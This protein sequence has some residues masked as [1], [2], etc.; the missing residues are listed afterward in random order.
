MKI[1]EKFAT[2]RKNEE[3]AF[4]TYLTAGFPSL[5]ESIENIYLLSECG[6]DIIELGVPFSDPIA[7]G[8]SIQYA[9][10]IALK[11]GITLKELLM[12]LRQVKID[13]P[14]VLM[15][16]LNP[17][18]S[19]KKEELF[20]DLKGTG[21]SGLIIPD[22]PVEES[23]AWV[24]LSNGYGINIIFLVAPTSPTERIRLIATK[25]QGFIYCV[26]VTG[27]TGMRSSLPPNIFQFVERVKSVT[28]KP[29]AVGF[30]I[31]SPEQIKLLKGKADGVI[32][33]SRIVEAIRQ[34][35]NLKDILKKL[36]EST[37]R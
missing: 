4:I 7:D 1:D 28:D 30:G 19:Y 25:S 13:K 37:R 12:G 17:L 14:L 32:V 10:H 9:S 8:P 5:N 34:K 23:D 22:L 27:T 20:N 2:L 18:L 21:F 24:S 15:S 3:M 31:S 35:E 11:N 16:Y 36:K 33:G 26:S 29:I 6:A